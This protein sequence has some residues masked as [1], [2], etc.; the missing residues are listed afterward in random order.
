MKLT[1]LITQG[2]E[3]LMGTFKE[4]PS[5]ITQGRNIDEVKENILDALSLYLEDMRSESSKYPIV[6]QE[7][8]I[9][10]Q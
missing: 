1:F 8:L 4:L 6:Y 2:F 7:E 10:A 9:L 3:F 5:V